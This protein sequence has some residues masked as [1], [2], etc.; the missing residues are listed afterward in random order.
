MRTKKII[1]PIE[2][3]A[4]HIHLSQKDLDTLFGK[5]YELKPLKPLSQTQQYA[6]EEIVQ[7]ETFASWG[8]PKEERFTFGKAPNKN[9]IRI[10]GPVRD[11]TQL[12]ISLTDAINLGIKPQLHVS[13]DIKGTNQKLVIIGP[14]ASLFYRAALLSRSG[15]F[16][17]AI[18]TQKHTG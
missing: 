14:K 3:S 2:I 17:R 8:K 9:T 1:V 12:E 6:A 7:I 4:R 11:H 13:G 5:G 16:T 10:L 18:K 15:T